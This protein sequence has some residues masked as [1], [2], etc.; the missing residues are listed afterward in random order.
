MGEEMEVNIFGVPP[1]V[2]PIVQKQAIGNIIQ[3][4]K[5]EKGQSGLCMVT[6]KVLSECSVRLNLSWVAHF[7]QKAQQLR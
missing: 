5:Q 3:S 2:S 4:P 7:L 1:D 6:D